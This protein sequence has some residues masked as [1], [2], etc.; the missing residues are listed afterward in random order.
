MFSS[1]LIGTGGK[2]ILNPTVSATSNTTCNWVFLVIEVGKGSY[3]FIK[4][5][6]GTEVVSN[7]ILLAI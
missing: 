7:K 1:I 2:F 4:I 5:V 6:L 3:N